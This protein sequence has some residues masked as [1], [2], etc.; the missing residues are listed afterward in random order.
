MISTY[1]T[2]RG[3]TV[4]SGDRGKRQPRL[5]VTWHRCMSDGQDHAVT[6][7]KM[8]LGVERSE[9]RY[10]SVC[11]HVLLI[12]SSLLPPARQCRRCH[13]FLNARASLPVVE[14]RL[15]R[16]TR[17]RKPGRIRQLF[18]HI[19]TPAP[20]QPE[21]PVEPRPESP[22]VPQPRSAFGGA[23]S[24]RRDGRMTPAGT[25]GTTPAPA[26]RHTLRGA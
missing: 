14:R 17:H 12:A 26:G 24:A 19:A 3:A 9:G 23:S 22:A 16:P 7:E 8:A 2:A 5:Y 21:T 11:G 15:R 25:G 13:A 18:G 1:P 6:D 10:D 20:R 4:T